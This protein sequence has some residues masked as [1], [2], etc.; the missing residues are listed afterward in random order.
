MFGHQYLK[1]RSTSSLFSYC[2]QNTIFG[3]TV[4]RVT[5]KLIFTVQRKII[6]TLSL[7][8]QKLLLF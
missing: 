5:V 1:F 7:S 8:H 2:K 6:K 3:P 4:K